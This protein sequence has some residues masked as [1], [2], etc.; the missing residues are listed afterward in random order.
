MCLQQVKLPKS[1]S[2]RCDISIALYW[3]VPYGKIDEEADRQSINENQIGLLFCVKW[4]ISNIVKSYEARTALKKVEKPKDMKKAKELLC[5]TILMYLE[6]RSYI[7]SDKELLILGDSFQGVPPDLQDESMILFEL[8]NFGG[9]SGM[10]TSDKTVVENKDQICKQLISE[11]FSLVPMK[12]KKGAAEDWNEYQVPKE[13]AQFVA[14]AR[15]VWSSCRELLEGLLF[16]LFCTTDDTKALDIEE[17]EKAYE[18]LPLSSKPNYL[19]GIVILHLLEKGEK[20]EGDHPLAGPSKKFAL[21]EDL[22]ADIKK[23]YFFWGM[24]Q[25]MIAGLFSRNAISPE[26]QQRFIEADKYLEAKLEALGI[27][28]MIK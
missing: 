19:L 17:F 3:D 8:L 1:V 24:V 4:Y 16:S 11:V 25:G 20:K 13:F 9:F 21:A 22:M 12:L 28:D 14:V 5:H 26:M 7:S 18:L 6:H 10:S 2:T 23:G 15:N 27:K